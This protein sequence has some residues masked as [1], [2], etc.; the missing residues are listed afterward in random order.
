MKL[1]KKHFNILYVPI[2]KKASCC[3]FDA[4]KY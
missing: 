3:S 2:N 4:L 1:K